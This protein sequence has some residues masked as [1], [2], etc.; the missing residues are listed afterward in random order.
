MIALEAR[1][2]TSL[3]PGHPLIIAL[4]AFI[5]VIL[6]LFLGGA[7]KAIGFAGFGIV[8]VAGICWG[9]VY[10]SEHRR[11]LIFVLIVTDML[12]SCFLLPDA[13]QTGGHYLLDFI[14]CL[15]VIPFVWRSGL[16]HRGGFR[17]YFIY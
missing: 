12:M 10:T 8:A 2:P 16:L 4:T 15:P 5:S 13:V 11:W 6:L 3:S 7:G 14:F 1:R 9:A 17:L